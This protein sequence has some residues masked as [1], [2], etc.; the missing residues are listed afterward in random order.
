VILAQLTDFHLASANPEREARLSQALDHLL[1]LDPLP[2]AVIVTGDVADKGEPAMYA[3]AAR[4]LKR[5]PMPLFVVPGNRDWT[6]PFRAELS[7]WCGSGENGFLN[8]VG[9]MGDLRLIGLDSRRPGSQQGLFSDQSRLWLEAR[10]NEQ[11]E[12][13]TVIFLHHPPF[14][15]K[16]RNGT[17]G[18]QIEGVEMLEEVVRKSGNVVQVICGHL[19]RIYA[20]PFAGRIATSAPSVAYQGIVEHWHEKPDGDIRPAATLHYWHD[21]RL[22]SRLSW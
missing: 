4:L 16:L 18:H 17:I 13:S 2:D 7:P 14:K 3:Q 21:G 6:E 5:L 19:H 8:L 15:T 20:V 1:T 12:R 10:L 11:P 22:I 9:E